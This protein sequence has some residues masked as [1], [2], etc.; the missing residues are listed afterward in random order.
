MKFITKTILFLSLIS[1]FTDIASEMLYPIMPMYLRSIGFSVLLIGILE[2]IAEAT[3]GLSKGY[4][5]RLSDHLGR[6]KLFVQ[7][8]Y[9]LSAISKP[10]MALFTHPVWIF[11]ARTADRLG[12]GVRTAARDAM[13]SDETTAE[14]KGR[15]F[16]FHRGFDTLGA[17][18]GPALALV[19]LTFY[20]LQ[21]KALFLIAF[22]PGLA[23]VF[24]TLLIH[25]KSIESRKSFDR[26]V[27]FPGFLSFLKYWRTGPPEFRLLMAGLLAFALVNSS[28]LLLLLMLKHNG[29]SDQHVILV[30]IGYNLVYALVSFPM[31]ILGDKIGLKATFLLGLFLFSV[32]YGGIIFVSALPMMFF[33][34]S[35]YG[36][37]AASTEGISKAWISNIVPKSET[38]TAIGFYTGMNS[39][40]ALVASS[41]AGWIWY[42]W[43]APLTFALSAAGSLLVIVY[44]LVVFRKK[45]F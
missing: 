44:F 8:G 26:S 31:G 33:L 27:S 20:P 18:I 23:A 12:K 14:F 34:F 36:I 2:G 10:A 28:D 22:F 32:V 4:F 6:R 17:A 7:I 45:S 13:L 15:V 30:Y 21:Y 42:S 35:L 11:T 37:Y 24:T 43:G 19:F 9:S 16:G 1:L 40:V 29:A 38:A 25:E 3:A 39:I 5:G 41:I